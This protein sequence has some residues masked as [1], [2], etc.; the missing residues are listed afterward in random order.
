MKGPLSVRGMGPLLF[1]LG[2]RL[3]R[4]VGFWLLGFKKIPWRAAIARIDSSLEFKRNQPRM[5]VCAGQ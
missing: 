5:S 1:R 3:F 2:L 4:C